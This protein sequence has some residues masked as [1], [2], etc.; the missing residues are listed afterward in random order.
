MILTEGVNYRSLKHWKYRTERPHS[1]ST[2]CP[3]ASTIETPWIELTTTGILTTHKGFCWDGP[4][5]PTFDRPS[6]MRASLFHD[7]L[8]Q[9]LRLKLLSPSSRLWSDDLLRDICIED[10]MNAWWAKQV[11]WRGIRLFGKRAATPTAETS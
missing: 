7:A 2:Q 9:L 1:V 6:F 11:V 8:Y 3:Q 10:G 4:S 5:G